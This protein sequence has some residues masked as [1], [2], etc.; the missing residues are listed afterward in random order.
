MFFAMCFIP[1]NTDYN[2]SCNNTSDRRFHFIFLEE[3]NRKHFNSYY[4]IPKTKI[5]LH[6]LH[7]SC[8]D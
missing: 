7:C 3:V 2:K 4:L 1:L 8:L 5:V 6:N